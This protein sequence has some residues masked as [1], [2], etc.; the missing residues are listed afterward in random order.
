MSGDEIKALLILMFLPWIMAL[1]L[2][3]IYLPV[4][5]LQ[6]NIDTIYREYQHLLKR[7]RIAPR[8]YRR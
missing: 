2:I 7:L 4:I 3:P 6:K 8:Q 5:W 1:I